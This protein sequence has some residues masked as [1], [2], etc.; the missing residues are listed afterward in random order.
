MEAGDDLTMILVVFGI[1]RLNVYVT[2]TTNRKTVKVAVTLNCK[3]KYPINDFDLR[4]FG[5][6]LLKLPNVACS[7]NKVLLGVIYVS[8]ACLVLLNMAF[9]R[10]KK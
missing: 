9:K 8:Q 6:R 5:T 2:M 10:F 3:K 4:R 7:S 1:T